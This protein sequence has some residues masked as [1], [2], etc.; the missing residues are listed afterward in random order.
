MKKET[1]FTILAS[2]AVFMVAAC[3]PL[4]IIVGIF[5]VVNLVLSDMM[6]KEN[7]ENENK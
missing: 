2:I 4:L 1:K 5:I 6:N 7:K 3:P